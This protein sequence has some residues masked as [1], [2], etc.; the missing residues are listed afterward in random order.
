MGSID[1][2]TNA[3]HPIPSYSASVW[4]G[5][6]IAGGAILLTLIGLAGLGV[7]A[8]TNAFD[9]QRAEAI[10]HSMIAYEIPGGARGVF[11]AN[12][13]G[14]K[15]AV[16]SSLA[17]AEP[18]PNPAVAAAPPAVELFVARIPLT[19]EMKELDGTD[20]AARPTYELFSG[21]SFSYQAP[22]A[23]QVNNSRVENKAFCGVQTP[24]TIQQGMLTIAEEVTFP[25]IRY[26]AEVVL[27]A[28]EHMVVVSALGETAAQDAARVFGSLQCK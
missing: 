16:L 23:F 12:V 11:G 5:I 6:A 7:K 19:G 25:A 17:W 2:P 15:M 27:D 14:G 3:V 20:L 4:E 8:L 10:A 22:E 21:F 1:D 28:D 26:Q 13:G 9:P 18:P 24:V